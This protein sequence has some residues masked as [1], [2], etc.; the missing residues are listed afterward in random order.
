MNF[1]ATLTEILFQFM[2]CDLFTLCPER[3]SNVDWM[4]SRKSLVICKIFYP[5]DLFEY[6]WEKM[7]HKW[8]LKKKK[9]WYM[10]FWQ[11]DIERKWIWEKKRMQMS[12]QQNIVSISLE[13]CYMRR[14]NDF[15]EIATSG[16]EE[17][18]P[19]THSLHVCVCATKQ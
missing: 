19:C 7:K 14:C 13:I 10:S 11:S 6:G 3:V 17:N 15:N 12:A 16:K 1:K 9:N 18:Y 4:K 8:K 2:L 5:S